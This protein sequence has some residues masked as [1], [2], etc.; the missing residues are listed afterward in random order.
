[1]NVKDTKMNSGVWIDTTEDD[2][3]IPPVEKNKPKTLEEEEWGD[4]TKDKSKYK[5]AEKKSQK[6]SETEGIS[7]QLKFLIVQN[8]KRL[9]HQRTPFML[10]YKM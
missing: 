2:S 4:T 3:K 8:I 1:M 7:Y 10:V 5:H 6:M 9:Q